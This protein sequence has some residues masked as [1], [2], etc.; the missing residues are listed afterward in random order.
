[1][2]S[3]PTP[4]LRCNVRTCALNE[5]KMAN[6]RL[7]KC[8]VSRPCLRNC[9]FGIADPGVHRVS[10]S[11]AIFFSTKKKNWKFLLQICL[12]C[13][14]NCRQNSPMIYSD[15]TVFLRIACSN[16]RLLCRSR[17]LKQIKPMIVAIRDS[18]SDVLHFATGVALQCGDL[19]TIYFRGSHP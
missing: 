10:Q 3:F 2:F 12:K 6:Y 1:M 5:N 17:Y 11:I 13:K 18:F 9:L 8:K 19:R 16:A 14:L 4:R 15:T 7:L